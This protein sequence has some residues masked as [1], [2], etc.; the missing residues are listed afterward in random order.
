MYRVKNERI[1]GQVKP[2]NDAPV[3]QPAGAKPNAGPLARSG[4][5]VLPACS[6]LDW[7]RVRSMI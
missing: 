3:L 1:D 7:Y 4:T 6:D 5:R 2:G